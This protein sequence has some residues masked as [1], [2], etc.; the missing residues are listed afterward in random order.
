MDIVG[1]NFGF[2]N[3][4]IFL[5]YGNNSFAS[6]TTQS[7]GIGSNPRMVAIGYFNDDP[8]LDI[9]VANFGANNRMLILGNRNG[10]FPNKKLLTRRLR[11]L[12]T[13]SLVI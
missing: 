8:Q 10:S 2:D 12:Y 6:P 7:T 11:V 4:S 1:A 5:G 13:S 3:V 9:V